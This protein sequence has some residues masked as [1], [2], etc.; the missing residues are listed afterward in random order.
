[1][2]RRCP[3]GFE[4]TAWGGRKSRW[5]R[6]RPRTVESCQRLRQLGKEG[7]ATKRPDIGR[8]VSNPP[9]RA[10]VSR[11]SSAAAET[12]RVWAPPCG[13]RADGGCGPLERLDPQFVGESQPHL[14][15]GHPAQR[16][17]RRIPRALPHAGVGHISGKYGRFRDQPPRELAIATVAERQHNLIHCGGVWSYADTG[18]LFAPTYHSTHRSPSVLLFR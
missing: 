18:T 6:V 16:L 3:S 1:L 5:W 2:R 11:P 15:R 9:N 14:V 12:G 7:F 17:L 8:N 4:A 10:A 13:T